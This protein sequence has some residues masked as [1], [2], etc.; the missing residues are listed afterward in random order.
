MGRG[1]AVT[2]IGL[3]TPAGIGVA[4]NWERVLTGVSAAATDPEL[5]GEKVDI[6]C[7]VPGFDPVAALGR[8]HAWKLDRFTQLA[9][10][11]ARQAVADSGLDTES[12]DRT[13]VG[14]VIGNSLGGAATLEKQLRTY[15]EGAPE[16]V[17]ALMIPMGMVNMVA[18]QVAMDLRVHGP[19]LVTATACASGASAI[20]TA[21]EW[22]LSGVCDV[23]LAGGTESA[24]SPGTLNGLSRMGALSGRTHD[25]AAAS[26]P[27]AQDRDGFVAGEGA[28]ILVL[29]RCADAQA[30]GA[31]RYADVAGFGASSDAHH[32]TAPHPQGAG[33]A[34]ALRDALAQAGVLPDEVQHVNAHGTSTPMNDLTEARAL[35][36]VFGDRPAVTSTKGVTGHTLAAAGAVEAAYTALALHHGAVP[37]TANLRSVDPGIDVDIDVVTS[38]PRRQRLSVAAST[39]LGFGGHNAALVLTAA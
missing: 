32:A 33:L 7:R 1:V 11:G 23:V 17:S 36:A 24:I 6:S 8:R 26:R 30:R 35:H 37:P 10:V 38:G 13:R 29:E 9:L 3:V 18:G 19:S 2:G 22:L 34:R 20:G 31:R 5:K 28:A 4:E 39:S 14:V 16:D 25:P 15:F 27:F 21:R 12:W